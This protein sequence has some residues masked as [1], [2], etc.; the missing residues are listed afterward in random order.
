MAEKP[1]LEGFT[2]NTIWSINHFSG[3]QNQELHRSVKTRKDIDKLKK[4]IK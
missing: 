4:D 1:V 3:S 2:A